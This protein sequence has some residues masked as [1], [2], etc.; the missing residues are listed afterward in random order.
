MNAI[1]PGRHPLLHR[2]EQAARWVNQDAYPAWP[3]V[4]DEHE[5]WL[6]FTEEKGEFERF[7]PRLR[8][9]PAQRDETI[10][11][12]GVAYFLERRC[13]LP[14]QTWE[15]PGENGKTGEFG[16]SLSDGRTMFVEVKSPG[17]EAEIVEREGKDSP[18]LAQPMHIHGEAHSTA[19]WQ[20]VREAVRKA[21]LKMPATTPTLLVIRDDLSVSL[22]DWPQNVMEI[23]LHCPRHVGSTGGYMAE[24]GSFVGS[25]FK[26]LGA[27][28][29]LNVD[30]PCD[31]PGAR[32]RFA[33]YDNPNCLAAV[34]VPRTILSEYRPDE[35]SV[36]R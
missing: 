7:L 35:E 32:Y 2:V 15:P 25:D 33:V 3:T 36:R 27:E 19:P 9:R 17:W 26:N 10:A 12:I 22:N 24:A 11:E 16:I 13:D 6:R 21:Y 30:F 29:I 28:G 8:G 4:A 14:I 1:E 23:A 20:R 18:R 34:A 31:D 5:R